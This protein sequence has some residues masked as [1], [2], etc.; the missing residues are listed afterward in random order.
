MSSF[1]SDATP[2]TK[3]VI[4]VGALGFLYLGIAYF[5]GLPPFLNIEVAQTRGLAAP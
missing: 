5:A 1:W 4:I 3:G 2:L